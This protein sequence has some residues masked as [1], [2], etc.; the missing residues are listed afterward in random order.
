[1]R[2][3]TKSKP[4]KKNVTPKKKSAKKRTA[5]KKAGTHNTQ[6][7]WTNQSVDTVALALEELEAMS[8]E[9][10]GDL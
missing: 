4:A 6:V 10:T 3:T 9:Q 8:G 1:M 5:P 7:Q 2:K